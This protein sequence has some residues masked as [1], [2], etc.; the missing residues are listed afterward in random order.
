MDEIKKEKRK[1]KKEKWRLAAV[2]LWQLLKSPRRTVSCFDRGRACYR[3]LF[4]VPAAS[5]QL[6]PSLFHYISQAVQKNNVQ[7]YHLVRYGPSS[8]TAAS[9]PLAVLIISQTA[10]RQTLR[11]LISSSYFFIF[12]LRP[13]ARPSVRCDFRLAVSLVILYLLAG[14]ANPSTDFH[15]RELIKTL[16]RCL[17]HAR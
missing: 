16:R 10:L 8:G 3:K 15:L 2:T 4:S 6:W 14:R 1:E 13:S 11:V 17:H 9:A 5:Q 12:L 7:T